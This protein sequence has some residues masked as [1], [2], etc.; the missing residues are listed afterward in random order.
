MQRYLLLGLLGI[1]TWEDVRKKELTTGNILLFGIGGMLLHLF[2]PAC[3]IYSILWGILL[4]IAVMAISWISRGGIGMGDGI[5]LMVTGVYLGGAANLELFL[6][7]LLLS[8]LWALALVVF[9]KKKGQEEIAFVPFL[10]VSY[11]MML[12]RWQL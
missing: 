12:V 3:S 9:W 10:L 1:C 2:V 8:F 11:L 4:G 6:M 7:G 5:L